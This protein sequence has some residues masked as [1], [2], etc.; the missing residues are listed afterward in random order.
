MKTVKYFMEFDMCDIDMCSKI[1]ISK[2]EYERQFK[3]IQ[4]QMKETEGQE[5]SVTALEPIIRD[6]GTYTS[7]FYSFSCG[8]ATTYLYKQECKEGYHFKK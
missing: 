8:C 3:F 5:F 6:F 2:K 1:E 7:S 4:S